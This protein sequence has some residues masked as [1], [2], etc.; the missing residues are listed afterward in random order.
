ME[1]HTV[2]LREVRNQIANIITGAPE[3]V[4]PMTLHA[5]FAT[6]LKMVADNPGQNRAL[7]DV[8]GTAPATRPG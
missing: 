3:V 5:A 1:E 8:I 6:I 2:E 7:A 4:P